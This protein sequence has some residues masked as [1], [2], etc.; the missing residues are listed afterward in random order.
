MPIQ[1][2]CTVVQVSLKI[3]I[4]LQNAEEVV[5]IP[6]TITGTLMDM[7]ESKGA[8]NPQDIADAIQTLINMYKG[9]RPT[10]TVVG[11]AFGSE[12]LNDLT[13]PVQMGHDRN[14][15]AKSLRDR[16]KTFLM[17]NR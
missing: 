15:R 9:T 3:L 10:R 16:R 5:E 14:F 2:K 7:F 11:A 6:G 13:S 12:V 8:P 4:V 17:R 1:P